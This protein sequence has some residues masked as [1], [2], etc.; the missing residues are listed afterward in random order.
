L[1]E[2]VHPVGVGL[3]FHRHAYPDVLGPGEEFWQALH[4]AL[5]TGKELSEEL[6]G[7]RNRGV[8]PERFLDEGYTKDGDHLFLEYRMGPKEIGVVFPEVRGKVLTQIQVEHR[9]RFEGES[10]YL[11]FDDGS[12]L[13]IRLSETT[14]LV[15]E[16][17]LAS[18]NEGI[19]Q[20]LEAK[21][22]LRIYHEASAVNRPTESGEAE[23]R[24]KTASREI[25][26]RFEGYFG[27]TY[28]S[29]VPS[30][31]YHKPERE[32]SQGLELHL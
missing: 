25:C 28:E 4:E 17:E 26:L 24:L 23:F 32:K 30:F 20:V 22:E 16:A 11:H 15:N 7:H 18:L 14:H 31:Y 3:A 6:L 5:L 2:E 9:G 29:P 12:A 1:P 27:D 10:V 21:A 19:G 8:R 13:E